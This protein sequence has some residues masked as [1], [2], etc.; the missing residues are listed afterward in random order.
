MRCIV[1]LALAWVLICPTLL[2]DQI[3]LKNGDRLTGEILESDEKALT[4]QSEFAGTVQ[5][6]W[7]AVE[8]ISSENPLYLTLKDNQ[9]VVGTVQTDQGQLQVQ[10]A[11][12][13]SV[14]LSKDAIST[15]R[16]GERH[17]AYLDEIDRLRNPG[18]TDLWKGSLDAGLSLSGGNADN[19]VFSMGFGA[20]RATSRDKITV[21]AASLY[22][23]NSTGGE[24]VTTANAIRGGARYDVNLSDR[25]F[26][27][28][29]GD[30]EFDEFQQLD[31]RTVLGGGLGWHVTRSDRAV[32]DVFGG[33]TFNKEFFST[34]LTRSSGEVL[35]GEELSYKLSERTSLTER[36]VFFPN[37]TET[38]E[39]RLN[40]DISA[41]TNIRSWFNWH[42]SLS[43]RF[44]SN[45]VPGNERNDIL[46]TTGV[47]VN[48]GR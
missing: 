31:L 48:F 40:F 43:N 2:A 35:L 38:G 24:S 33:G 4:I 26:V 17:A 25:T 20:D 18:L 36:L 10:T 46:L 45:P 19:T 41:V 21:H 42:V 12:T 39:Y 9:R 34:G 30:L 3:I 28:G 8:R 16:S 22:A 44:L 14:T 47:R 32:F 11:E 6:Q 7:S 13:G 23:T 29:L 5:V 15:I 1:R 27:F 37:L